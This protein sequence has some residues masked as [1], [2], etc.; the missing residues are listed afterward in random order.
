MIPALA[1]ALLASFVAC[2]ESED[3]GMPI[4]DVDDAELPERML[5]NIGLDEDMSGDLRPEARELILARHQVGRQI[6]E[7]V[8]SS[9][10][11]LPLSLDVPTSIRVWRRGLDGS[12]GSCSGRVDVI[13]L[14]KYVKGVLP[15]EWIRSWHTESLKAGA[16]AIRTYGS[17]W[18]NAGGKYSCADVDD[19]TAS[20][21]YK[22]EFYPVTD[23]AVDA[24]AATFVVRSG[25]LVFTEYSAENSDPTADGVSEPL[26]TGR[27]RFGHG[28]GTCQWGSQRW[29]SQSAKSYSWILTHYYPG[30]EVTPLPAPGDELV[31]DSHNVNNDTELG[32][33][34][35]GTSWTS[36]SATPG[37]Y[38]TGYYFALT[39]A[40]SDP[41]HF[42]FYLDAPA[43]K[44]LDAWWTAGTNRAPA[45]PFII[46]DSTGAHLDTIMADQT[47]DGSQWNTLGTWSFPAGWNKVMLSR[48]TTAGAVVIADAVRVR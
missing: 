46:V 32:Y 8:E 11:P 25:A 26:C 40:V 45:A 16:V 38:G 23:T 37:Y 39:E 41:A 43:T 20:Q 19:T 12:T 35:L 28:R 21:V 34:Q 30:S 31:V 22:D 3:T 10:A 13:P 18:V 1:I 17:W 7:P 48:W 36:A 5:T 44:T 6:A 24:T 15:H 2:G 47:I 29:A 27:Q 33:S 9:A 14:E 4:G 42:Y